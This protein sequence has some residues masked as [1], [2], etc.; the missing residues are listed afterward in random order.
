MEGEGADAEPAATVAAEIVAAGG[1]AIADTSDVATVG[2]AAS[3]RRRRGRAVRARRHPD[4]QRRHHPVGGVPGGRRRQPRAAP[5]RARRR[6]VQHHPRRVAAHGRAGLRP[7]RH[8]DLHRACSGC[9][10]NL[11]YA[12]AKG[13]VIGLTRSL[14]TAG[15]AHGIKVNLIAPAAMTRM[16]GRTV[17]DEDAAA[18][19]GARAGRADGRLPRPRG[20]PGQRRDL[21]SRAR[22]GSRASSSPSTPG[23]LHADGAPTIEDVAAHWAAI[24]D[25]TG[26]YVPADL[27]A[28]SAAFTSHLRR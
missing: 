2:G 18:A 17:E 24:N 19:D 23:Y 16:A 7:H 11:S 12:T 9:P 27:T 5:R 4:Q 14:A 13:A 1:V 26:Y 15:A 10:T 28:W 21:R 6:L 25:E 8:D 20:L 22:A 3:A